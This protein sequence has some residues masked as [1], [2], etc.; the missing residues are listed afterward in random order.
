MIFPSCPPRRFPPPWT[1]GK[2]NAC[3]IVRD[4]TEH[5][6]AYVYFED[7]SAYGSVPG[8]VRVVGDVSAH[9]AKHDMR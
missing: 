8:A 2:P 1:V 7:A 9:L 6:L 4:A 5:A 3:F